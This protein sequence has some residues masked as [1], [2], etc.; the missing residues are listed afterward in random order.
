[1]HC[2]IEIQSF[3]FPSKNLLVVYNNSMF[4]CYM[5]LY[6]W[7]F[8]RCIN[9]ENNFSIQQFNCIWNYDFN[10]MG[11]RSY[12]EFIY[13]NECKL[14]TMN[15]KLLSNKSL[16]KSVYSY[17]LS[18]V[19]N[20]LKWNLMKFWFWFSISYQSVPK[21]YSSYAYIKILDWFHQNIILNSSNLLNR[22]DSDRAET[23]EL[24]SIIWSSCRFHLRILMIH[25]Q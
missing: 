23:L 7:I 18:I 14:L 5:K 11:K 12:N 6:L 10:D 20:D 21:L 8:T 17:H 16:T 22:I 4:I 1:M 19:I 2:S 25:T 13:Q 15:I 24:K 3:F 9:K